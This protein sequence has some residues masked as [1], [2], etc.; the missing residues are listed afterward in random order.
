[1]KIIFVRHAEKEFEGENPPLTKKGLKQAK[2]LAKRLKE[3]AIDEFYCSD[4][5]RAR[6]TAEIVSKKIKIKPKIE[7]SLR[8]L[9]T[10]IFLKDKKKWKADEKKKY[11][12]LISFLKKITSNPN[13]EKTI[14]LICHGLVNRVIISYFIKINLKKTLVL[15]Q[16]ETNINLIYWVEKF[17]N[18]RLRSMND[19]SHV[20]KKLR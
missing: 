10:E 7:T 18:W 3:F 14:L 5:S 12:N 6:Q 2:H 8:E 4:L 1:M 15:R 19:N 17:K 13:Q 9:N 16:R 11:S 20:P